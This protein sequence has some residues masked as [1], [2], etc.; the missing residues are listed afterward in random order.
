MSTP[1]EDIPPISLLCVDDDVNVL[2]VLKKYFERKPD[3]SV[4]TCTSPS[5]ALG[6]ISQYQFDAII[7][8]YAMPDMDGIAL[9]K[10]IRAQGDPAL[11]IIFTGRHLAQVAIETLN[12][13]GNYYVQKG[14]DILFDIT[15][16]EDFIRNT[17]SNR[18]LTHPLPG[19]D[20]RY[21]SLVEQQPD[22]LCCFLPDGTC[23]LANAPYAHLIGRKETEI[24][25]TN[26]LAIIPKNERERIQKLLS[27]L[28]TQCPGTYIEHHVLNNKG[29]PL[30]FQWSYRAF[31]NEKGDLVEYLAQ[32][33][34]LSCIVRLDEILPH[35][36][37]EPK[38]ECSQQVVSPPA[39]GQTAVAE[40]AS[41]ADSTDLVQYPI[42]AVDKQGVVIAWNNAMAELTG[43]D[44][45]TIIG[46]GNF[47]YAFAIY[48]EPRPMLIDAILKAAAGQD[49]ESFPGVTRDGD[50]YNG[51]VEHVTIQGKKMQ[52]WGKGTPIFDG[53]GNV[54]AAVQSLL[55][56]EEFGED[57]LFDEMEEHYIGGISSIILKVAGE[58][59]GGEIAGAIGSATGGYGVYATDK[60]LLVVHNPE[61]DASR[62]DGVQFGEFIIDEL[63]GTN[64]DTRPRSIA[65]LEKIKVFEVWRNN[66]KSI[67]MKTPRF[68]A[69]FL[70]IRTYSG[71][72]FR[73]FVDHKKAFLHLEQLLKLFYPNII[74]TGEEL[75]DADLEWLDEIR[76]LELVGKLQL[77]DPFKDIPHEE[78][79]NLPRIPMHLS[80]SVSQGQC[81]EIAASIENV[82][83]PIFAIDRQGIVIAWNR[84]I[85][86]L[87]GI[88][89]R[90]MIGKGDYEYS[91]PFYGERKPM[92]I[93]YLIMP[94]DT[95]V[96]GE[97]PAIT[98][99]GDTFIGSLESVTIRGKPMLIWGKG[100]GIYDIKGAPIAAIQSI[101]Y[102]EQPNISTIIRKF[103]EEQYLGGLSSITV[104]V[105]G[106]GMIGAIA[107]A[108]GS[109][110]GG[111]GIYATD[112]RIFV[113]HNT[114]LDAT[115]TTGMQFGEFLMDELFGTT[116]DTNPRSITELSELKVFEVARKDIGTIEL[117]KPL[118][119]A[120]YIT[121]RTRSGEVFRVYTDHRKAY[122]HL[123]QL[124]K[125]YYPEILRIE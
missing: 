68:L 48:G 117:K 67:E 27:A 109:T 58:G 14:V 90:E 17:V 93:D 113:I 78:T 121:F 33:R 95:P 75:D 9:L 4:F 35:G 6:L 97:L 98:R 66:I 52:V 74:H 64:V 84:A 61:L 40:L 104:K 2:D 30:L 29:E 12:N 18:R 15:K 118:L 25:Q 70:I 101:L 119:F 82:P 13:G 87:T 38:P 42:F 59:L 49:I 83:Y 56:N 89:A 86:R 46:Q 96:H 16:V 72:S 37:F 108:L 111:Y 7:S 114:E 3:F 51:E 124:L 39:P 10:E 5:E 20:M 79:T 36:S 65:D 50:V 32:G 34:D 54:I 28:T 103:E 99:E 125:L 60:R 105:P 24:P 62:S 76:V 19:S 115:Q 69:G 94:P 106:E 80:I 102:S 77:V 44:A 41:L 43:V 11:F 91:Y 122:I 112:Q 120:G 73:I 53:K 26:F 85:T 88:E 23:T 107:G 47:A 110:T 92:L 1:P 116:V 81:R 45:R 100:T 63:F 57:G 21:R 8:D 22:L 71:G 31:F 55:A 123:E